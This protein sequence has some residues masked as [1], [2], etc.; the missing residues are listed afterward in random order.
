MAQTNKYLGA[1]RMAGAHMIKALQLPEL[2]TFGPVAMRDFL[3]KRARYLQIVGQNN[4][5]DGVNVTSITVV[6]S[7]D[8]KL[9]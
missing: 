4:M 2:D 5:A 6:G 8:P 3:K 7:I 1:T 9:L